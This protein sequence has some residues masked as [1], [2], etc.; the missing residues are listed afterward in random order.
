M[1]CFKLKVKLLNIAKPPIW[2]DILIADDITFEKLHQVIQLAMG[3][4]FSHLYQFIVGNRKNG[5]YIGSNQ[6]DMGMDLLDDRQTFVT[7]YLKKK[8]DK[9]WYEYDFGDGWVHEITVL[10]ILEVS[11]EQPVPFVVKGKGACPPEDCGGPWGYEELKEI[12]SNPKSA[13]YEEMLEWV[14]GEFDID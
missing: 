1:K 11:K 10:D 7:A 3:W 8:K 2:R 14:G 9:C 6:F 4:E 5:L 13:N 12:L